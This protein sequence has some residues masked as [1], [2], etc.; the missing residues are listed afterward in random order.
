MLCFV[1]CLFLP[2]LHPKCRFLSSDMHNCCADEPRRFISSFSRFLLDSAANATM[3]FL[4]VHTLCTWEEGRRHI[5]YIKRHAALEFA[6]L[7]RVH[8]NRC[9][10]KHDR[11]WGDEIE[12]I[13]IKD[14]KLLLEAH[15]V[16]DFLAQTERTVG[17][18]HPEYGSY[19]VEGVPR[20]PYVLHSLDACMD[21]IFNMRRRRMD[22]SDAVKTL[23]GADAEVVSLTSFPTMGSLQGREFIGRTSGQTPCYSKTSKSPLFPDVAIGHHPRYDALTN[24][25]RNRKGCRVAVTIPLFEDK[26]TD[27]FE[28]AP[29]SNSAGEL[30]AWHVQRNMGLEYN[31][32]P[33]KRSIYM[34]ATGFGAGLCCLQT[35]F[36][37]R[38]MREARYLY[39]QVLP[40]SPISSTPHP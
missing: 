15:N 1:D 10:N 14:D 27:M 20:H 36:G 6:E 18:Y 7:V 40:P 8:R 23:Y 13:L 11:M 4:D 35:T 30:S 3:G 12:F 26:N 39:D 33:V 32:N 21:V 17:T 19:M 9:D 22:I 24:N 5:P 37:C 29:V 28:N 2:K 31:P 38:C 34:D 16:I 25:I